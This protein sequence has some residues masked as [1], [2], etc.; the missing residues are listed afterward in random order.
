MTQ[1]S[2][3]F[4]L[5]NKKGTLSQGLFQLLTLL[6]QIIDKASCSANVNIYFK[7]VYF[8]GFIVQDLE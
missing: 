8:S 6:G 7:N 3:L 1:K 5:S 4:F 2:V